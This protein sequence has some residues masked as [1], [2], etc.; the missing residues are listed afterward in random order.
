MRRRADV[1]RSPAR[2]AMAP[3]SAVTRVRAIVPGVRFA[4]PLGQL[5]GPRAPMVH[6][7]LPADAADMSESRQISGMRRGAGLGVVAFATLVIGIAACGNDDDDR[8][9]RPEAA[10]ATPRVDAREL[11]RYL[12]R[13]DEEPGFRR[14]PAPGA[15]PRERETVTG[16]EAFTREMRLPPAD[17]RRLTSDGF[18]AFTSQPI[19]GPGSA[20]VTNV[21][22]Y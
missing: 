16:V 7:V 9:A 10:K 11:G 5:I 21:A 8:P 15:M 18:L 20:G 19:R 6:A 13:R 14:G 22:L 3:S 17:A 2:W 1:A 4:L 12:M